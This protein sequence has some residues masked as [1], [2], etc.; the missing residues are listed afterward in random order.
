MTDE[1]QII[2]GTSLWR[3]AWKRL[4]RNKLAVFGLVVLGV[5]LVA[6]IIG[7]A[8]ILDNRLHLRPDT[9]RPFVS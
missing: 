1:V 6:V 2:K 9:D 3:D 4:L 8:M 7:P 5:L